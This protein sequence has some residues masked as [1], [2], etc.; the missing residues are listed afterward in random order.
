VARLTGML[1]TTGPLAA[2]RTSGKVRSEAM[3]E[4]DSSRWLTR[5][6]TATTTSLAS[7]VPNWT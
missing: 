7:I 5:P 3:S 1:S 4:T 2:E 6:R